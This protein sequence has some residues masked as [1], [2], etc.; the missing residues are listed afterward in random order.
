MII[1]PKTTTHLA[2]LTRQTENVYSLCQCRT[3]GHFVLANG[4]ELGEHCSR[5][6][7][8]RDL[9]QMGKF[10]FWRPGEAERMHTIITEYAEFK[11]RRL[12]VHPDIVR[13]TD[14]WNRMREQ[15]DTPY[16][17]D[18]HSFIIG[19]SG[20]RA[21]APIAKTVPLIHE[22]FGVYELIEEKRLPEFLETSLSQDP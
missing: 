2:P 6:S 13:R 9:E 22:P 15:G 8:L 14:E 7:A 19:G 12:S 17:S 21:R 18:T 10:G 5:D 4:M 16:P 11:D 20:F 1:R 3:H